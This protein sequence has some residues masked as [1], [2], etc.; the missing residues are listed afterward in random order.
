MSDDRHPVTK[1]KTTPELRRERAMKAAMAS[2]DHMKA[3]LDASGRRWLVFSAQ[4]M[5]DGLPWPGGVQEFMDLIHLYGQR[6]RKIPNG[7]FEIEVEP[8]TGEEVQIPLYK[9]ENLELE[10]LDRAIRYLIGQAYELD[11]KWSLENPAL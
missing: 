10:E 4:D 9:D 2:P 1:E 8:L 6:R 3:W 7:R 11:P 5:I